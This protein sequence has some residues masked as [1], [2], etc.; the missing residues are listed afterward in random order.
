MLRKAYTEADIAAILKEKDDLLGGAGESLSE[1]EQEILTR[2]N[3]ARMG[4]ERLHVEDLLSE[5]C[6]RPYGWYD[7]ATLCLLAR[8]FKRNKVE[9]R[10]GAETLTAEQLLPA[11]TN[12][13]AYGSTAVQI[14]EEFDQSTVTELRK[15]HHEFFDRANPAT[16][17]KSAAQGLL[18]AFAEEVRV[19]DGVLAKSE[20]FSFVEQLHRSG[21]GSMTFHAMITPTRCVTCATSATTCSMPRMICSIPS[22]PS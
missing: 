8:L 5:F 6:R 1:G 20:R 4:G 18:E 19:L 14:Q 3:R 21:T 7:A 11:L 15:F 2:L 22:K 12:S 17:A 9:V 10:Q 13:R 16:D